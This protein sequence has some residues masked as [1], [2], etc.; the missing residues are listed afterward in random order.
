V[1]ENVQNPIE[2]LRCLQSKIVCGRQLEISDP[3]QQDDGATN[4][5]IVDRQNI[6][7]TAFD[8][9]KSIENLRLT[10]EVQFYDEVQYL[11]NFTRSIKLTQKYFYFSQMIE[12]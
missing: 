3:T 9:I 10:L 8:E 7:D 6:I 11:D 4:F 12:L 5:I 1:N 2:I